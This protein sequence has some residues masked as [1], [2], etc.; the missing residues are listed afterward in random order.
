MGWRL[1][2]RRKRAFEM[3]DALHPQSSRVS[4]LEKSTSHGPSSFASS[5]VAPVA[6]FKVAPVASFKVA[7]VSIVASS[8][9]A[10]VSIAPSSLEREAVTP[11]PATESLEREAVPPA[12]ATESLKTEPLLK[13]D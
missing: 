9:V 3:K 10:P 5:K 4:T 12:P 13:S 6:S 1:D 2:K 8:K 7:P 11:A